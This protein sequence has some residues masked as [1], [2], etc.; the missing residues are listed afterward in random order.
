M[1]V[2]AGKA[3][4][5]P[6]KTLE[7]LNTRPTT[8][9]IKETLFNILSPSIPGSRFL[10]LFAGSGG[11]GIEALSRGAEYAV[12]VD[13]SREAVKVI[14][15]NL[16]FTRLS[17]RARVI[18]KDAASAVRS[19]YREAPFD[20]VYLDAP[21][22]DGNLRRALE[23]LSESPIITRSTMLIAEEK[24]GAD[25]SFVN[26]LGFELT[27]IKE[28]KTNEHVFLRKI[29]ETAEVEHGK[30]DRSVSGEL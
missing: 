21:Y 9:R 15:E 8:D 14:Q 26:E 6:L 20:L 1:R 13:M 11:I 23:A 17:D 18:Q 3:R 7:G 2:I 4:S 25:F 27:R 19:L 10:D 29:R 12:L 16:L 28:Y 5:L 30:A 22:G 24:K